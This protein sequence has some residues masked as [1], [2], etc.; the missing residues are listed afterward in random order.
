MDHLHVPLM[1]RDPVVGMSAE[2]RKKK[3][4]KNKK[5]QREGRNRR[6]SQVQIPAV[7]TSDSGRFYLTGNLV[8][9]RGTVLRR[10]AGTVS[11]WERKGHKKF[12]SRWRWMSH[13]ICIQLLWRPRMAPGRD[14]GGH[15]GVGGKMGSEV[16]CH[17]AFRYCLIG[18][19]VWYCLN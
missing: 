16:T 15:R 12:I 14:T 8:I 13:P 17:G 9:Y 6:W 1:C 11:A 3:P 2:R 19:F 5:I 10:G 18:L 4:K 7:I